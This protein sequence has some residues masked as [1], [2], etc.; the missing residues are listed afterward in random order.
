MSVDSWKKEYYPIPAD[1]VMINEKALVKHSLRKWLGIR[2][3]NLKKHK[4]YARKAGIGGLEGPP[5]LFDASTC[6]LCEKHLGVFDCE[7]CPLLKQ[8]GMPCGAIGTPYHHWLITGNPYPMITELLK[9][10]RRLK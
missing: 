8:Q 6:S 10:Y 2:P 7:Y 4:V 3:K 9:L 1:K 5:F